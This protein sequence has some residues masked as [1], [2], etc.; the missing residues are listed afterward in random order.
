MKRRVLKSA[1]S[2]LLIIVLVL[3]MGVGTF[4]A[5]RFTDVS[6]HWAV[7]YIEKWENANVINGYPD[8]TFRPENKITRAETAA[9]ICRFLGLDKNHGISNPYSDVKQ[10]DWFY[11]EV[12]ACNKAGVMTGY[13]G[14]FFPMDNITRE[15]VITTIGRAVNLREGNSGIEKFSDGSKVQT[16]AKGYVNAM[17][18]D[19]YV[20]G[21]SDNTLRPANSISRAEF[22]KILYFVNAPLSET[23]PNGT[24]KLNVKIEDTLNKSVTASSSDYLSANSLVSYEFISLIESK[25]DD[26]RAAFP[27]AAAKAILDE[28][29]AAF[30]AGDSAWADYVK[31]NYTD[32]DEDYFGMSFV[33]DIISNRN[34]TLGGLV[35]GIQ[36]RMTFNDTQVG[37]EDVVYTVTVWLEKTN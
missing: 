11:N 3:S 1:C 25:Y 31:K 6:G 8:N 24:Y 26:F 4:A 21:Y 14:K 20:N 22:V 35:A 33:G 7:K 15:E 16:Y 19:G 27:S 34:A 36:Y 37:R 5:S 29:L 17:I 32:V 30:D 28:G 13:N 12:L 10:S 2:L 23:D 18:R 9:V